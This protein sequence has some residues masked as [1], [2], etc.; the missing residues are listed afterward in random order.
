MKFWRRACVYLGWA[1]IMGALAWG[2]SV[3]YPMFA[4][5]AWIFAIGVVTLSVPLWEGY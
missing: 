1:E 4:G 3:L 2:V 5:P